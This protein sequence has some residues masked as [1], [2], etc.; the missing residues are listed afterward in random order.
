MSELK[1]R[2]LSE[3]TIAKLTHESKKRGISREELL[4]KILENFSVAPALL[5]QEEKYN[6]LLMMIAEVLTLNTQTIQEFGK[7]LQKSL[8]KGGYDL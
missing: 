7:T 6:S 8:V 2:G 1:I 5:Q 4:R 3:E